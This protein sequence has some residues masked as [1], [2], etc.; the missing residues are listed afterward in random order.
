M[1]IDVLEITQQTLDK[2]VRN[3]QRGLDGNFSITQ[4]GIDE[5]NRLKNTLSNLRNKVKLMVVKK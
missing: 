5:D 4:E 3:I 2:S 1:Q